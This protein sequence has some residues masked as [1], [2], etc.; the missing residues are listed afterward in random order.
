MDKDAWS[1]AM[2][3]RKLII[4]EIY[5]S[6]LNANSK[7]HAPELFWNIQQIVMVKQ[8]CMSWLRHNWEMNGF[9]FVVTLL[10]RVSIDSD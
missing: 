3:L 6:V 7:H 5:R 1:V 2:I 10:Q 9:V 8:I 4:I